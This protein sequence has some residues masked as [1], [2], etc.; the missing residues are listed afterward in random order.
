M[1]FN[2]PPNTPAAPAGGASSGAAGAAVVQVTLQNF[3]REVIEASLATPV[4]LY[5]TAAWCGP[6]KQF[7]PMLEKEVM[8][9][10]GAVKLA[11]V[12]IDQSPQ[13]AQQFRI[14]SVPA[15]YVIAGGQ[16]IDGFMGV[17]PT[18]EVQ[19]LIK[20]LTAN[21]PEALDAAALLEEAERLLA[22]G[23]PAPASE[24]YAALLQEEPE[25]P[26]AIGGLMK[27][28]LALGQTA[29][30]QA[31]LNSVPEKLHTH[32]AVASAKAALKLAALGKQGDSEPL[33]AKLQADPLDHAA[34]Y[35]L[36]EL[37]LGAG[38]HDAAIDALLAITAKD[39]E[40]EEQKARTLLLT[41]FEALGFSHP[42]AV[43]GRKRLSTLLFS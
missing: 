8:A 27:C 16:P 20:K 30:A 34:R 14:Q 19:A 22:E 18:S 6:C 7:G 42:S 25:K 35:A 24:L 26:E 21:S 15:V 23:Q 41:I 4:L 39:R 32:E 10:K 36:A 17:L 40:W 9:A 5:F 31:L 1:L 43:Q 2:A 11:K 38:Q 28:Y 12:D 3:M 29:Q 37:Y 13:I 33:K